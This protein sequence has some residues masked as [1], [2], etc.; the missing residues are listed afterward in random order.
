MPTRLVETGWAKEIEQALATQARPLVIV[1]PFI[2]A[3]AAQRFIRAGLGSG[4][5]VITRFN[6][7][8]FASGVSDLD[9]LQ[10][11][12]DAGATVRGVRD[13]HA[14]LYVFGQQ[15]AVITSANLTETAL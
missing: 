7:E 3:T 5:R 15:R 11:L 4:C 13:L 8:D 14:K 1:S 12:C 9:A 10:M 6:L 2:K